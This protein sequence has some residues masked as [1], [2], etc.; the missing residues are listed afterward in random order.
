MDTQCN[1]ITELLDGK[2][3]LKDLLLSEHYDDTFDVNELSVDECLILSFVAVMI[4]AIEVLVDD[5]SA[6]NKGDDGDDDDDDD[7]KRVVDGYRQFFLQNDQVKT[8]TLKFLDKFIDEYTENSA[9]H[10][11]EDF[12]RFR[13]AIIATRKLRQDGLI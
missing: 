9:M 6:C 13:E 11:K 12:T 5:A 8:N 7:S 3:R 1:V 4:G 10:F 2:P